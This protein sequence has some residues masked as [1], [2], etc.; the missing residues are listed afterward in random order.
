LDF[1]LE[2][3][4]DDGASESENKEE[5]HDCDDR[6]NAAHVSRDYEQK[7]ADQHQIYEGPKLQVVEA[8]R[9]IFS[10]CLSRE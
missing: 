9:G 3:A 1:S 4:L 6:G 5:T 2:L 8:I 7:R 10:E